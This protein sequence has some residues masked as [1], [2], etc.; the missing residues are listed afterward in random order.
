[1]VDIEYEKMKVKRGTM[2]Q[3]MKDCIYETFRANY[4]Q[5]INQKNFDNALADVINKLSLEWGLSKEQT[6]LWILSSTFEEIFKEE[7][8]KRGMM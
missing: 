6:V 4:T 7:I 1:M 8:K 3:K 5:G 2:F